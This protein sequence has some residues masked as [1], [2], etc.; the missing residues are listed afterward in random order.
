MFVHRVSS[1]WITPW[2]P[3][4]PPTQGSKCPPPWCRGLPPPHR[5]LVISKHPI[6]NTFGVNQNLMSVCWSVLPVYRPESLPEPLNGIIA[7]L[8]RLPG[9]FSTFYISEHRPEKDLGWFYINCILNHHHMWPQC[10][11]SNLE[12]TVSLGSSLKTMTTYMQL[13]QWL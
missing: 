10:F 11:L 13:W 1:S 6:T 5:T 8:L 12:R 7:G 3:S 4:P 9:E 2:P